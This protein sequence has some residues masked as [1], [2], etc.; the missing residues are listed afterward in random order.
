MTKS[1]SPAERWVLFG[2]AAIHFTHVMDFMIIM[3]LGPQFM[4]AFQI[5]PDGFGILVSSYTFSAGLSNLLGALYLDRFP[6]KQ[7]LLFCFLG[8]TV[9][10]L[11]CALAT[12]YAS[13]LTA[14]ILAGSFGGLIQA[15]IFSYLADSFQETRR[16]SATGQV[17]SAFALASI[18]GVPFGLFLSNWFSWRAPFF[19]L[20]VVA[21]GIWIVCAKKLPK[22]QGQHL[23]K[24][25]PLLIVEDIFSDTNHLRAFLLT[26]CLMLAGFTVIPYIS[27]SV[28]SNA[29]LPESHL[30]LIYFFGGALAFF[31]S[32]WIGRLSDRYGKQKI[33][34]MVASLSC[35]PIWLVTH[36]S[37]A[38]MV[39]VLS[40]TTLFM[41]LVSGRMVPGMAILM[42]AVE[43]R[44]RGSFMSI[45]TAIQQLAAGVAALIS[46]SIITEQG[47][48]L[49]GY[50]LLG[51]VSVFATVL[52]ILISRS[53]RSKEVRIDH[54]I[55]PG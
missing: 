41:V 40:V 5:G 48:R 23:T 21:M 22:I 37:E 3:P 12:G 38:P 39:W 36:L 24:K 16:G 17:M 2:L 8:H 15:L 4:R 10:T 9:T 43:E 13:F 25:T 45:N 20:A 31:S 32:P 53:I 47:G 49:Y 14:R 1:F 19:L 46:A 51:V 50:D 6:R 33:F 55:H 34:L 26:I 11:I 18:A 35:I 27:P 44:R 54:G 42:S 29:G 52:S 28:V 30:P 7:A